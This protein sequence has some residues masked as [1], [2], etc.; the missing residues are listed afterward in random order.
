MKR[1]RAPIS[2]PRPAATTLRYVLETVRGSLLAA[3]A[4]TAG[5]D[6]G[7]VPGLTAGFRKT[8]APG[9]SGVEGTNLDA[10]LSLRGR[11]DKPHADQSDALAA[12]TIDILR[13]R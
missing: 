3:P 6:V 13:G 4:V 7:V 10:F 1:N 9:A 8:P 12:R 2:A 11:A 5:T